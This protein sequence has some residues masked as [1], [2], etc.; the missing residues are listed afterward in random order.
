MS[1]KYVPE[2]MIAKSRFRDYYATWEPD[3][4]LH[5]MSRMSQLLE[6]NSE[7]ADAKTTRSNEIIYSGDVVQKLEEIIDHAKKLM[8]E[9]SIIDFSK[10]A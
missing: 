8:Q 2:K 5:L 10:V 3:N 4:R 6:E 1:K 7:Y 9:I